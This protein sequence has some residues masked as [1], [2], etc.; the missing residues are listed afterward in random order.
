MMRISV[1]FS[2]KGE[3]G[4]EA[5]GICDH[6]CNV[7]R[8]SQMWGPSQNGCPGQTQHTHF[9]KGKPVKLKG[10]TLTPQTCKAGRDK[11]WCTK[12]LFLT[13]VFLI[14]TP[15]SLEMSWGDLRSILAE[16]QYASKKRGPYVKSLLAARKQRILASQKAKWQCS[17]NEIEATN[18]YAHLK[19]ADNT[20]TQINPLDK[21]NHRISKDS[22]DHQ[23]R[24]APRP[25]NCIWPP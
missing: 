22:C 12:P 17:A 18:L 8:H 14:L 7:K 1:L 2:E 21:Q 9:P 6:I 15:A 4:R 16:K 23:K 11:F 5:L 3:N 19:K 25:A 10:K 24:W 20:N 13:Q